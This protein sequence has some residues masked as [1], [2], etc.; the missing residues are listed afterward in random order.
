MS[1]EYDLGTAAQFDDTG[2]GRTVQGYLT[3][4]KTHLPKVLP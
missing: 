4:R 3:Y 1:L 2:L